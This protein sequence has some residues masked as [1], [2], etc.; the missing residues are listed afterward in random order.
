[1]FL[2]QT[3]LLAVIRVR[4]LKSGFIVEATLGGQLWE[5]CEQPV[6]VLEETILVDGVKT[7]PELICPAVIFLCKKKK[8]GV[9]Q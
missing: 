9:R 8:K 2:L 6:T 1:M 5:L 7:I 4:D 3:L